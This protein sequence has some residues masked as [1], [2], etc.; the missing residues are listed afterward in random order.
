MI[1]ETDRER[2]GQDKVQPAGRWVRLVA[3]AVMGG[4]SL[5]S[6]ARYL[7][8]A[9]EALPIEQPLEW[10]EGGVVQVVARLAEGQPLYAPP[11]VD[12]VAYIYPPFYFW[13]TAL[14]SK[15]VGVGYLAG[16]A[17]SFGAIVACFLLVYRAVLSNRAVLSCGTTIDDAAHNSNALLEDG[18]AKGRSGSVPSVRWLRAALGSNTWGLLGVGV[19]AATFEASGQW[20]HLGRVDSLYQAL[21][22]G[23]ALLL[24]VP[25]LA[26]KHCRGRR[27][28]LL[29]GLLL[30]L[31]FLTKQTALMV[32][33][34][35]LVGVWLQNRR[36]AVETGLMA[37][38]VVL[39]VVGVLHLGSDGWSSYFLFAVAGQHGWADRA[40]LG[41]WERDLW[42]VAIF[43]GLAVWALVALWRSSPRAAGPWLGLTFGVVGSGWMSRAHEG[44][45]ENVVM[46]VF[47]L[48][49]VLAPLGCEALLSRN[50]DGA[51][52]LAVTAVV[53]LQFVVLLP[54]AKTGLPTEQQRLEHRR[55]QEWVLA[56]PG[57]V[58]VPDARWVEQDGQRTTNGLGMAA[59]DLLRLSEEDRGRQVLAESLRR[60]FSD[61]RFAT[62]VLSERGHLRE[63]MGDHYG[64]SERL[65]GSPAPPSGWRVR[66]RF[67]FSPV[68]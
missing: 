33:A 60:A 8:V 16:R 46:P 51:G 35:L 45:A 32:V 48:I 3:L 36:R 1:S 21:L 27:T 59:R 38:A 26:G 65:V 17:V 15:L 66:S 53:G 44:G 22:F 61:K 20:F 41:F 54:S 30:G 55:F 64:F 14:V 37:A 29:A 6:V 2:P 31:A 57:E 63:F 18:R 24:L 28:V 42:A 25:G 5:W 56:Q 49:A 40:W 7:L 19:L 67:V 10:M 9:I 62:I 4:I 12:Y 11:S 34:P 58:L 50:G 52:W 43:L 13:L 68:E 39:P 23:G 47:L